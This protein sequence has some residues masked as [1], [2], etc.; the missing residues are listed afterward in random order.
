MEFLPSG[1]SAFL[2]RFGNSISL[3]IHEKIRLYTHLLKNGKLKGIIEIVPAYID[4]TVHY[5][6]IEI[7]YRDLVKN[8]KN[9]FSEVQKIKVPNI[10]TVKI[11]VWYGDKYGKDISHVSHTNNLPID[12]IIEIH[13]TT[14]YTVHM[15][16]FTP[17]FCYLGGMD[18]RIAT[19]RK[20][21]P[22][23]KIIA[24]S[25]GIAANQTGIYPIESPGGWQI[26]GRT[27]LKIFD[28]TSENPFLIK[29]GDKLQFYPIGETEYNNMNEYV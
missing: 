12:K 20:E 24:G 2:I 27:P 23:P 9:L 4:I 28:P 6:P 18:D 5:N 8:I 26:I 25:V 11:P 15:L 7:D 14:S 1:D 29:A 22:D 3:K 13:S 16:G 10:N 17:G 21:V 19:P